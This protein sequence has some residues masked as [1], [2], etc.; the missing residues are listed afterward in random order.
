MNS[1]ELEKTISNLDAW[2]RE[3]QSDA[4]FAFERLTG[5]NSVHVMHAHIGRNNNTFVDSVRTQFTSPQDFISRWIGGLQ[6]KLAE[7]ESGT[8][9]R[10][11]GRKFSEEIVFDAL[12]DP[13]LR[14]YTF[15]FL[16]RNFFRNFRARMRAKPSDDLWSVWFGPGNLFW[17]LVISPARR[18]SEWT[19][20]KSQMRREDYQYWTLGHVMATGLVDPT[21]DQPSTFQSLRDFC[22]FYRSVLK[23]VS[24]SLYE[25]GICDR[26]LDYITASTAPLEEPL[27]IPELRYAGKDKKHEHR[28]DFA[29]LNGHTSQLTGFELS[30][31]ST[32]I[33]VEGIKSKTQNSVNKDLAMA[34]EKEVR[35][36]NDYFDKFGISIVTF[37][38]RD[39]I[40][41]DSC[42]DRIRKSLQ[43]RRTAPVSVEEALTA[44]NASQTKNV[45]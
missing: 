32:H 18:N 12:Q 22:I 23:R 36:R 42:F 41:L 3:H 38:D 28:L 6:A 1:K 19:N 33:R 30:P 39:L 2:I 20:D 13:V 7:I 8:R 31:A 24:N 27:L 21:S 26:Y 9:N 44:L 37:A 15:K 25:Q 4:L 11:K 14:A 16:E 34:W 10:Y 45:S 17:G 40:D 43:K 5:E 29:V 35:K